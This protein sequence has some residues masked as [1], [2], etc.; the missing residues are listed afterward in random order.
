MVYLDTSVLI[1]L[2]VSEIYSDDVQAF[3]SGLDTP[4][5]SH[6]CLLEWDCAM[7]RMERSGAITAEY[8]LLAVREFS[9]Q[10]AEGLYRLVARDQA[11]FNTARHLIEQVAPV[12][13][14]AMDA[15]HLATA[16]ACEVSLVA[17]ADKVM[18]DAA[19]QLGFETKTFI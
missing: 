10:L 11:M 4:T 15:L 8:R 19:Q 17:T 2:F 13:L 18:T 7:R 3:V 16:R 14:R 9:T 1:K 5:V 6:L 12:P